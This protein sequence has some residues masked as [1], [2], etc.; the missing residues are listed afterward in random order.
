MSLGRCPR[1]GTP[2]QA[3]PTR[4]YF[5]GMGAVVRTTCPGEGAPSPVIEV[6]ATVAYAGSLTDQHGPGWSVVD[7]C[8]CHGCIAAQDVA[9]STGEP[10]EPRWVLARPGQHR[11]LRCVG[12]RSLVLAPV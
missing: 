8:D 5:A 12:A 10:F 2:H 3:H 11:G 1:K 7:Q 4:L 6:G 9:I